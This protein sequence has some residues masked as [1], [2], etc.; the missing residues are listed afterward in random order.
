MKSSRARRQSIAVFT[1]AASIV[2]LTEANP[3][4]A[5][6]SAAFVH[7]ADMRD[8]LAD[9]ER[10][11]WIEAGNGSW[12][13]ARF[14]GVCHGVNST[15]AVAFDTPATD[16]IDRRSAVIIPGGIR[17]RFQSFARSDGPPQNRNADLLLQ[18]QSQ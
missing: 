14:A 15:N 5:S 17:C 1:A 3:A 9:G 11:L 8:W 10:G 4:V 16:N 12:F 2:T 13:Y 7:H 18:P 6:G